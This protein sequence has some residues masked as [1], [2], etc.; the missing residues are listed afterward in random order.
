MVKCQ[1]EQSKKVVVEEWVSN[2]S[3]YDT[4]VCAQDDSSDDTSDESPDDIYNNW[5]DL[6]EIVVKNGR[7][8]RGGL[9]EK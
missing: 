5:D 6:S 8:R 2:D 4:R 3:E 9:K 1:T 7:K